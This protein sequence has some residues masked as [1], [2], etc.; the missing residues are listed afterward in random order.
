MSFRNPASDQW[1]NLIPDELFDEYANLA[2]LL[3]PK[4]VSLWGL[5]LVTQFHDAFPLNC[6]NC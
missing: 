6:K 4:N 5:N 1:I 2:P 3:P